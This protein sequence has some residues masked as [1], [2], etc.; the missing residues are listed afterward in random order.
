MATLN[1][2]RLREHYVKKGTKKLKKFSFALWKW[3]LNFPSFNFFSQAIKTM[4]KK[5]LTQCGSMWTEKLFSNSFQLSSIRFYW[6]KII[7][8]FADCCSWKAEISSS[9]KKFRFSK[10]SIFTVMA[11]SAKLRFHYFRILQF[12]SSLFI[13]CITLT[14]DADDR[15]DSWMLIELNTTHPYHL[16]EAK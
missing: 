11:E 13:R 9:K 14:S 2:H 10:F 5:I 4:R 15:E 12:S 1:Q 6:I 8:M 16:I 3:E 7:R